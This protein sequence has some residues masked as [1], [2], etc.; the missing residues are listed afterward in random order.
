MPSRARRSFDELS[1]DVEK[2]MSYDPVGPGGG[3][4]IEKTEVLNKS[5]IVLLTAFW[6]AYCE[7]LAVEAVSHLV[8]FAESAEELPQR[9]RERVARELR[10]ERD[11]LSVWRLADDGWRRM[12]RVRLRELQKKRNLLMNTPKS[13]NVD[14]IFDNYLG[15]PHVS[16]AWHWQ[17][18]TQESACKKLDR[19]VTLR[20]DIAHRG[21]AAKPVSRAV[22]RG[23]LKHVRR[24]VGKTGGAVNSVLRDSTGVGL[25]EPMLVRV[26]ERVTGD[27]FTAAEVNR[28]LDT[29]TT[30]QREVISLRFGL[31]TRS[32][33][34]HPS[35][36]PEQLMKL[37]EIASMLGVTS[38][39]IRQIE[40][41]ALR[42]LRAF[43]TDQ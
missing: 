38:K 43:Q 17:G 13:S 36:K 42:K 12:L 30:S 24:I 32:S 37:D 19:M 26:M 21:S 7:D 8:E 4:R 25:W 33:I 9:L 40:S 14:Y 5:A 41:A 29:L 16:E 3:K 18:M 23:H 34:T 6:E 28:A 11:E 15:V 2:L 31:H 10:K 35:D 39:R 20:G 1:H 27:I 22:A